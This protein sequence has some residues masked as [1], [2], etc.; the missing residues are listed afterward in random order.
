ML[1]CLRVCV[2]VCLPVCVCVCVSVCVRTFVSSACLLR[3]QKR[4]SRQPEWSYCYWEDIEH[5]GAHQK[6]KRR[7]REDTRK[8]KSQL[9]RGRQHD[10]YNRFRQQHQR[11]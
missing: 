7:E 9:K 11:G 6:R 2:S 4:H 1:V 10:S 5:A 3:V 8:R